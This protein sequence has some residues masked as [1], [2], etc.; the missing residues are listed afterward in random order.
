M[1]AHRTRSRTL[2]AVMVVLVAAAAACTPPTGGGGT[3]STTTVP[4]T[5]APGPCPGTSGVTVVVDFATLRDEVVVRCARGAQSSGLAALANAGF[6]PVGE[7]GVA[8]VCQLAGLPTQGFPFCWFTGG[9][10]SYWTAPSRTASWQF[11]T[12]GPGAGP[13]PQGSVQGWSWA[14]GFVSTAPRLRGDGSPSS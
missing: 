6:A 7:P 8:P 11:A 3:P 13:L 14:P 5:W 9:Y 10:W 12:T 2:L 4:A 1:T